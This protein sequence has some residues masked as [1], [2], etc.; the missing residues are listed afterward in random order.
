MGPA[1]GCL[2][3]RKQDAEEKESPH[4]HVMSCAEALTQNLI[5]FFSAEKIPPT[6]LSILP[7][8]MSKPK[9]KSAEHPV[10]LVKCAIEPCDR[11]RF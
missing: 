7:V 11:L 1:E 8:T 2:I 6:L 4:E 3:V 9:K 10:C 5:R